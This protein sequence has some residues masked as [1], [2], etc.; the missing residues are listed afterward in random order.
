ML[1]ELESALDRQMGGLAVHLRAPDPSPE[2]LARVTA[3]IGQE[4]GRLRRQARRLRTIRGWL[5]VAAAILLVIV[6]DRLPA[7]APTADFAAADP[8]EWLSDW[9]AA[10][11]ASSERVTMLLTDEWWSNGW[12]TDE[13]EEQALDELLDSLDQ[14]RSMLLG[15]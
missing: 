10:V 12:Q 5:G 6:L 2:C 14:S 1:E 3:A 4:A 9:T 8:V 15:A 7:S 13:D 11:E